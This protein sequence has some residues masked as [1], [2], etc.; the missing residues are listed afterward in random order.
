MQ[1]I[2]MLFNIAEDHENRNQHN[3]LQIRSVPDCPTN[4]VPKLKRLFNKLLGAEED[5]VLEI[6]RAHRILGGHSMPY[7]LF[8]GR[9]AHFT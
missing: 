7:S 4:P 8:Y 9:R 1:Q 6:E 3:N 2:H 5:A